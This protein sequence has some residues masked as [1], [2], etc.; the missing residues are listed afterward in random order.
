MFPWKGLTVRCTTQQDATEGAFKKIAAGL[1]RTAHS[2][3]E[4]VQDAR[5][6]VPSSRGC[7]GHSCGA[8]RESQCWHWGHHLKGKLEQRQQGRCSAQRAHNRR[9]APHQLENPLCLWQTNLF[10]V[11]EEPYKKI[12]S[13]W[14]FRHIH[15]MQAFRPAAL[16]TSR[17]YEEVTQPRAANR[18]TMQNHAAAVHA[19][20]A[21]AMCASEVRCTLRQCG[22]SFV[23]CSYRSSSCA[24]E[25]SPAGGG[26]VP[27]T[28]PGLPLASSHC[29][30]AV[31]ILRGTLTMPRVLRLRGR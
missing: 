15:E 1:H 5:E 19:T 9:H 29:R 17:D 2:P 3:M 11:E 26:S 8:S 25:R 31:T 4:L 22:Q 13:R 20:R 7:S 6:L 27:A 18:E 30:H 12:Y 10:C 23:C 28:Q 16:K 21:G 24:L 14:Y